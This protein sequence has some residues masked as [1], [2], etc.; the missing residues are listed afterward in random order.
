M[1][2]LVSDKDSIVAS[3]VSQT[4]LTRRNKLEADKF[5]LADKLFD[6]C[7]SAV[8]HA[9]LA[10]APIGYFKKSRYFSILP[11]AEGGYSASFQMKEL[12]AIP[13]ILTDATSTS[14]RVSD[15]KLLA[16][17]ALLAKEEEALRKDKTLL[18]REAN[19]L[20]K[21]VRTLKKLKEVWPECVPFIPESINRQANV[22]AVNSEKLNKLIASAG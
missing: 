15:E 10:T 18:Q 11:F 7:V 9:A 4:L 22:P 20:L 21:K 1:N 2:L 13:Y 17:I 19:S 12:K 5:E 3:V 6:H 14:M 8:G 16:C